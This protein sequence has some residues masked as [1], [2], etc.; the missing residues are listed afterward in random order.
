MRPFLEP[1]IVSLKLFSIGKLRF[2]SKKT[3]AFPLTFKLRKLELRI[4]N[5]QMETLQ[6][7]TKLP[8]IAK[9]CFM[10]T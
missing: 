10:P 2:F 3:A 8:Y 4:E 5:A 1:D 7:R 9:K 6:Y